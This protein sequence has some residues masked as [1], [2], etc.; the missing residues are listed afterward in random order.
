[1]KKL[2][3]SELLARAANPDGRKRPSPLTAPSADTG[4]QH[5]EVQTKILRLI[6]GSDIKS[7]FAITAAKKYEHKAHVVPGTSLII[8]KSFMPCTITSK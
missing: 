4:Q 3:V 5:R 7:S 8:E 2:Q 1:M 6:Q